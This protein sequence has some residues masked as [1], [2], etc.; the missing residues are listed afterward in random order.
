M[1]RPLR[2][3]AVVVAL[4]VPLTLAVPAGATTAVKAKPAPWAKSVCSKVGGWRSSIEKASEK[5]ASAAPS[6]AKA[7]KKTLVKLIGRSLKA[8]KKLSKDLKKIGT[9][10]V[11]GGKQVSSIIRQGF[12]Q[13]Q[14]TLGQ[15]LK[16]LKAA[17]TGDA[18]TFLT[19]AR[20]TEDSLEA[21]LEHVEQA[22][23]AATLIDVP[24]L[25]EAFGA[26]SGCTDVTA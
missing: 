12:K 20:L 4:C 17:D 13:V 21:G 5:A 9:P 2:A 6:T 8:T 16:E 14:S 10:G 19:A 25:V 11:N 18:A 7:A 26:Q 1:S 23:R 3:L 15:A 24:E 22:L